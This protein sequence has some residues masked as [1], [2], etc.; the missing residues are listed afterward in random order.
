MKLLTVLLL[1]TIGG[2]MTSCTSEYEECLV[3]G[4]ALRNQLAL[5]EQSY[6][7]V[8]NEELVNEMES[9]KNEINFLAKVSGNEEL[10][11]KQ[12]FED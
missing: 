4:L 11:L 8:S 1:L 3:Q 2:L 10:F 9:I 6:S 7:V 12:V 5:V